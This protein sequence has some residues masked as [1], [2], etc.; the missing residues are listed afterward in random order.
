MNNEQCVIINNKKKCVFFYI[1]NAGNT[2][3]STLG[4]NLSPRMQM[5]HAF[6]LAVHQLLESSTIGLSLAS[7]QRLDGLNVQVR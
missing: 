5:T 7:L 1:V 2:Q 3:G 4:P 6:I